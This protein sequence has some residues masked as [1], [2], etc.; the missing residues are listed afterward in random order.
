MLVPAIITISLALVFYSV[1]VW[2]EK[3]SGRLSWFHLGF[4]WAG[5]VMDTTG[6]TLMGEIAGGLQFNVH[7]ITGVLALGLMAIHAAWA[8]V[9]LVGRHG[10]W[11]EKFHRF[12]LVV[13]GIWL[14]PY[15]IGMALN[16]KF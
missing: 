7:G 6:T 15:L 13:W 10:K 9:V 12:S 5:F 3:L 11:I 16:M 4:F 8:T 1:G 2:G 14:V